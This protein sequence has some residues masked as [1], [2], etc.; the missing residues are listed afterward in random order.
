VSPDSASEDSSLTRKYSCRL[1]IAFLIWTAGL[2]LCAGCG[3]QDYEKKMG[4]HQ[5]RIKYEAE[6]NTYLEPLQVLWLDKKKSDDPDYFHPD[7]LFF[8]PPQGIVTTADDKYVGNFNRYPG[9]GESSSF[10][11]MLVAIA[12]TDS[13]DKFKSEVLKELNVG[14]TPKTTSATRYHRTSFEHTVPYEFYESDGP[15]GPTRVFISQDDS[16]FQVAV[17]FRVPPPSSNWSSLESSIVY[18]LASLQTGTA[19]LNQNRVYKPPAA[20]PPSGKR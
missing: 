3:L 5:G 18:S 4:D 9:R 6:E 1:V 10:K 7:N 15:R 16:T 19:A 11:E 12:R 2:L 13:R 14:G 20:R 8:R 17:A